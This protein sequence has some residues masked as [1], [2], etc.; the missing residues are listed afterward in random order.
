MKVKKLIIYK[1]TNLINRKVY[2]GLTTKSL[3]IRKGQHLHDAFKKNNNCI[4]H[5]A[6]RKYGELNF[7][8]EVIDF[9]N[10]LKELEE[11]EVNWI[12]HYNSFIHDKNSN[13]YNSTIGGQCGSSRH[14]E[15]TRKKISEIQRNKGGHKLTEDDVIH[16]KSLIKDGDLVYS[17]IAKMFNVSEASI[18]KIKNGDNWVHV[19]EDVSRVKRTKIGG[20]IL[21][22]ELVKEIKLLLK[23]GIE[24]KEIAKRYVVASETIS[25]IKRGKI[26]ANVGLDVSELNK[27][28]LTD[29]QVI[30]IK[31][32]L[33]KGDISKLQLS[34][35]YGVSRHYIYKIEKEAM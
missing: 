24:Q 19:G 10:S 11:K 25:A 28:K 16:I 7:L 8:W 14:S 21:N 34:K 5:K 9:A 13:G 4:F 32:Y 15:E 35:M 22:E 17:E 23:H 18:T 33:E 2:I 20:A 31:L 1:V 3:K 27:P 12:S 26:W 6:L 30:E 29:E